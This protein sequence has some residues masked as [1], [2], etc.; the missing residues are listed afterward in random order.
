MRSLTL[1]N[2][3]EGFEKGILP[4]GLA[5][6]SAYLKEYGGITDIRLL[7]ANSGDIYK[8]FRPTDVVGVTAVT[9]DIRR[10]TAFARFVKENHHRPVILGGVHISTHPELPGPFTA[11]VIGE[12]EETMLELMRLP[13]F[14][15]ESLSRVKGVCFRAEGK[16]V[17]TSPRESMVPMER[18]PFPDRDLAD[19]SFYLKHR[20]IIPYYAGRSLTMITSRGCPFRCVF[21]S[22]KVHWKRYRGFPAQRVVDEI[23]YLKERYDVEILHI[24]D[25]L[26]IADKR[27]LEEIVRLLSSKGLNREIKFMCLVRSDMLDDRVMALLKEMNV[28][29]TGAGMESGSDRILRYLKGNTVTV[30]QNRRAV[31]LSTRWGIPVMGTFMVGNPLETEE[32][33]LRTLAFIREFRD[34]P[35]FTPLTYIATAFPGTEFWNF[36]RC[37]GLDLRD[38]ERIVMDIPSKPE[39]LAGAPLLTDMPLERFFDLLQ[40]FAQET[41]RCLSSTPPPAKEPPLPLPV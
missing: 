29:V 25:D 28:V 12:G 16:T 5:S 33:M 31:E 40:L 37:R 4:L 30:E 20:Q 17:F 14:S 35:Y 26:F 2:P 24:F 22:T 19:T 32:E 11:G 36:A 21:C 27:R 38:T 10:A 41:R 8:D 3:S 34:N 7:D 18:L 15:P 6:I 13:D 23:Q 39:D 1:V 9:Q